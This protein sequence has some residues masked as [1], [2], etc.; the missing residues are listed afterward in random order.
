MYNLRP[1]NGLPLDCWRAWA[2]AVTGTASANSTRSRLAPS[3]H[4]VIEPATLVERVCHARHQDA[5]RA[6]VVVRLDEQHGEVARP[7]EKARE[8]DESHRVGDHDTGRERNGAR[9]GEEHL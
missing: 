6:Q 5:R 1:R 4:C 7:P 2:L 3:V 8:D 9:H